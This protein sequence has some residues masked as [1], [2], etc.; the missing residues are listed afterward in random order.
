MVCHGGTWAL[1]LSGA[2]LSLLDFFGV[3]FF[4]RTSTAIW[5]YL[6]SSRINF[7][8]PGRPSS[9]L[10]RWDVVKFSEVA[11]S[12]YDRTWSNKRRLAWTVYATALM[13]FITDWGLSIRVSM[14]ELHETVTGDCDLTRVTP[15]SLEYS[16]SVFNKNSTLKA[17]KLEHG[18]TL[19]TLKSAPCCWWQWLD[20][21]LSTSLRVHALTRSPT[22][23]LNFLISRSRFQIPGVLIRESD[24]VSTVIDTCFTDGNDL[25]LKCCPGIV[26]YCLN[27]CWM[28]NSPQTPKRAE[29][30]R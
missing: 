20:S 15:A 16:L 21:G 25:F 30:A 29:R 19:I 10:R 6:R 5:F 28:K 7:A 9:A 3:F 2:G 26:N 11:D 13:T 23:N 14:F 4:W 1:D 24:L 18:L 27:S 22:N 17:G 8:L 12:V